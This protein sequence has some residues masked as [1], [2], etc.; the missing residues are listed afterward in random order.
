MPPLEEWPP[1]GLGADDILDGV[2]T[3]ERKT[4]DDFIVSIIDGRLFRQVANLKKNCNISSAAT[5][6]DQSNAQ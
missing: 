5:D 6:L 4:A 2:S 1:S 3:V